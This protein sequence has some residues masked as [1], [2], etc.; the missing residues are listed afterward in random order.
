MNFSQITFPVLTTLGGWDNARHMLIFKVFRAQ[1]W[2]ELASL[3]VT[4]GAPVDRQDGFVH[5][6]TAGQLPETLRRHFRGETGLVLVAIEAASASPW[7]KWE[8]SRD[9]ALFP[10]LYRDLELADVVWSRPLADDP[11]A[12]SLPTEP[13]CA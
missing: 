1:E 6:S 4:R 7:L 13:T 12:R 9:G 3:G 10:H 2:A 5:F 8:P 11:A